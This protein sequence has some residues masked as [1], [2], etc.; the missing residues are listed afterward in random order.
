M[1]EKKSRISVYLNDSSKKKVKK[2]ARKNKKP[3]N[4]LIVFLI[5]MAIKVE[6]NG[7]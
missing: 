6:T 1:S 7:L 4:Q 3:L 2:M 5:E